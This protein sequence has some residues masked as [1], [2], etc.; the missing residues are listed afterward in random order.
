MLK[1]HIL[2]SR[3]L[4]ACSAGPY[5]TLLSDNLSRCNRSTDTCQVEKIT[6]Q[7]I[8]NK[9]N[10]ISKVT[11]IQTTRL[12]QIQEDQLQ[13][14][15]FLASKQPVLWT[16]LIQATV[17]HFSTKSDDIA[18]DTGAKKMTWLSKLAKELKIL[19]SEKTTLMIDNQPSTRYHEGKIIEIFNH[20]F[21]LLV[22]N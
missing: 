10:S 21:H 7:R 1:R 11:R 20:D 19:C 4:L 5:T 16:S 15:Y 6:G 9:A 14:Y 13:V 17:T 22:D 3:G 12:T 8:R 18:A 2:A